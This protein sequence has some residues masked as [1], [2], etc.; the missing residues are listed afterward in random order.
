MLNKN[1]AVATIAVKDIDVARKFYEGVPTSLEP[2]ASR[3]TDPVTRTPTLR[4]APPTATNT[5]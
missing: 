4:N 3:K 1:D 2:C 5:R